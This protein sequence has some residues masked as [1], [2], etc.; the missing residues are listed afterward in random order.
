MKQKLLPFALSA[1]ALASPA[2]AADEAPAVT[3]YGVMHLSVDLLDYTD[4]RG[5]AADFS[6][7]KGETNLAVSS[8]SSRLGIRGEKALTDSTTL[9]YLAEWQI[10]ATEET[11]A[12]GSDNNL[13]R[14]NQ[15]IGLKTGYGEWRVGRIDTPLKNI[16]GKVD[17]F[18]SDQLG[19][20]RSITGATG[21]D[22][23]LDNVMQFELGKG[24]VRGIF[25]YSADRGSDSIDD[26]D[27]DAFSAAVTWEQGAWFVGGGFETRH[28]SAA[29]RS[30]SP[31][32]DDTTAVRVAASVKLGSEG[33]HKITGYLESVDSVSGGD[34]DRDTFGL[35]YS[36][37]NGDD[38]FKVAYYEADDLSEADDTGGS[39]ISLGWDRLISKNAVLY[40][41]AAA[42]SNDD[43]ANFKVIGVGHDGEIANAVGENN[44]GVSVGLRY[45][46]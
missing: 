39:Q 8:N 27:N 9:T 13:S 20:N 38:V 33:A 43:A 4:D 26:N 11:K 46:F 44:S 21:F 40:V 34:N 42:V 18:F 41:T 15:W 14:R 16:R 10:G 32:L 30:S 17:L 5:T 28:Y 31:T 35:G 1:L 36:F 6:D 3:V 7:D 2:F 12:N 37:K 23:R 29:D 25:Y 24:P 45:Q 19:E 22:S